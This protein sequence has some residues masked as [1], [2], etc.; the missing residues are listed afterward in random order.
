MMIDKNIKTFII[1][2]NFLS[3]NSKMSINI[4][5]KALII[6]LFTKNVIILIKYLDFINIF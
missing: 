1:Y 2:I 4:A 6:F 5:R 3:L